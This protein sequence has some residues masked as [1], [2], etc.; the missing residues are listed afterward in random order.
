MS[1]SLKLILTLFLFF[2]PFALLHAQVGINTDNSEPAP[3]AMLDVSSTDKGILIPRMT[4]TQRTDISSPATGLLVFD[5][6]TGSFWFYDGNDWKDLSG[7]NDA[8]ADSTNE[9]ELPTGGMDGQVLKT[10]DNGNYMWVD[11]TVDTDT[12]TQLSET[13]VDDFVSNN[14]YITSADDADADP[15]NEIELPTGGTDGQVLKTDGNGNYTWVDQTVDTDTNTQLS[16]TEVDDFVSNNGYITSADD[17]DADPTNEI[18]LPTGGTD[19]QVLKTD[20]NG[21]YTWTDQTVDTDTD[22]QTID[23]FSLSG[24]S[25][26]L[27][28]E[29]DGEDLQTVDLSSFKDNTDD[30]KIDVFSLSGNNLQ[31]SLESD[32]QSTKSLSLSSFKQTLSLSNDN[33]SISGGNA[34]ALNSA[35]IS[36]SGVT[37]GTDTSDD[38]LFGTNSLSHSSGTERKFFF[39]KSKGAFRAG[40]ITG[41]E[42]NDS[43]V[44]ISSTALGEDNKA[45]GKYSVALGAVSDATGSYAVALGGGNTASGDLSVSLGSSNSASGDFA[46]SIGIGS[47]ASAERAVAIGS[48]NTASGE[49][50]IAIGTDLTAPSYGEVVLGLYNTTY[51]PD[52]TSSFDE[53]DRLLVVGNGKDDDNLSNA[54]VINKAGRARFDGDALGNTEYVMTIDNTQNN[55]SSP[56]NGLL[57]RAGHNSYSSNHQSALIR[58]E[59]PDGTNCG[60]I[61]QDGGNDIKLVDSSDERLKENIKPTRYGIEDILKIEVKDYNFIADADDFVKTGFLAQQLY[62]VYPTAVTVGDDV[63]TNPWGVTYADLTPLLVKGMQDQ[64][65]IIEQLKMANVVLKKEVAKIQQL[66]TML[67]QLKAQLH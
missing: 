54:L 49:S 3:S 4:S 40:T 48:S 62:E 53:D 51:T 2:A 64:Q 38:F 14:G 18:E 50:A 33:L 9:I 22:N 39:D 25:L 31:I 55:N 28:L 23:N 19:G 32:G 65:E 1:N 26:R 29:D 27:S 7:T 30:Q 20:G 35:F 67:S 47:S 58:F 36:N 13:E 42:W 56:N 8:D 16:E 66:E 11:Q 59:R 21:N 46:T 34:I 10:D 44:G 17:A 12:N 24:N 60:R 61:R 63:K 45:S 5:T 43:N 52:K 37:Y 15:T 41:D 6:Q 57:I